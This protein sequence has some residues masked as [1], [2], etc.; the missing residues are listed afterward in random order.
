MGFFLDNIVVFL[1]RT[2]VRLINE[3]RSNAWPAAEGRV[4]KAYPP[5]AS[6]YPAAEV[7]YKYTVE[8]KT[9]T[10]MHTMAFWSSSSA[11]EYAGRFEVGAS[12]FVRYKPGEPTVSVVRQYD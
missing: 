1:F 5:G 12:L 3:H 9:Y 10:G 7:A 6:I 11:N 2:A 8:G 4:A